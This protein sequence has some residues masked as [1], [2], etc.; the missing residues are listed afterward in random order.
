MKQLIKTTSLEMHDISELRPAKTTDLVIAESKTVCPELNRFFYATV[1]GDHYWVDRLSWTYD[2]WLV[3]LDPEKVRTWIGYSQGTPAGY[4]EL[5]RQ[6]GNVIEVAY[7]GLLEQFAGKG[8]GGH[9][10]TEATREAWKLGPERVWLHT[11]TLDGPH[12]LQNYK[13]RGFKVFDETDEEFDLPNDP[14][15]SWPGAR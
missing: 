2:Q 11:C 6:E 10:L 14:P 13:S 4:F 1:G 7:F 3:Y 15:G 8:Y 5:E 9:L 12:A